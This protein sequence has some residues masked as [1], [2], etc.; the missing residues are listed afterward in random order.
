MAFNRS[1]LRE[2]TQEDKDTYVRDGVVCLRNVFDKDWIDSLLPIAKDLATEK[3]D[4]GL[5]PNVAARYMSRKI[6]EFRRLAF[7]SP[8]GEAGGRVIQTKEARFFFDEIFSKPPNSDRKTI[9]HCDR[10]GWPVVGKMVPSLWMPLIP[11]TKVNSLECWAGSHSQDVPYWLFSP[12]GRKMIQP[13]DRPNQPDVESLRGTPGVEILSWD[14]EPGDL[15]VV[16]PW[17]LHYSSGN[18]TDD[19][20]IA[21]S[22]R[23]FGDDIV[24][25]PR[26]DCLNI[27]GVSFDEMVDGER[28]AGSLFPL[29]WSDDGRRDSGE[30]FPNGF[31]TTWSENAKNVAGNEYRNNG[32]FA[33]LLDQKGGGSKISA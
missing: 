19:W 29:I 13:D 23:I 27:A 10:M 31:A 14:M 22:T 7:E 32:G 11:V 20:R 12:N 18:Q 28:P 30:D 3:K 25:K 26:P 21:I 17:T 9:W 16:H 5:L 24:W 1:P 8:M 2:I 6:S 15:L 4:Y 33:E